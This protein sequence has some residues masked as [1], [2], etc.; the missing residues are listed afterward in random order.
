MWEEKGRIGGGRVSYLQDDVIDEEVGGG[1]ESGA[2]AGGDLSRVVDQ[3]AQ[4]AEDGT[5]QHG[6]QE[7]VEDIPHVEDH[8]DPP[9]QVAQR[10]ARPLLLCDPAAETCR[11]GAV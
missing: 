8:A 7:D 2:D 9:V 11:L 1:G 4:L 5:S 10:G 6:P 3:D